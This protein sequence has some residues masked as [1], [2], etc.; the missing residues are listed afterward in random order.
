LIGGL[1]GLGIPEEDANLYAE[2]VRRGGTLVTVKAADNL[3]DRVAQ[4]MQRD[5]TVDLD[6][7]GAEW[8]KSGWNGFDMNAKPYSTS[9]IEAFRTI[10]PA[11]NAA[12]S[13]SQL[14]D[15]KQDEAVLPKET[16]EH[17]ETVR[18]TLRRQ[19]VH[20]Q[21]Q[22]SERAVNASGYDA[23]DADFR[24]HFQSSNANS[25]YTYDEYAPTYRYGYNL[26]S[27]ERTRGKDWNAIEADAR[28]TWEERNPGTWDQFKDTIRYAWEKARSEG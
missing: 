6:T 26:A 16:Q 3:A 5:G 7:A 21:E 28:R 19:D 4:I 25:G 14:R 15:L 13:E 1:I 27:S 9:D 17:T 24:T 2:G 23:Y 12:R 18:D 11:A 8:R 10:R 22:G 20:V